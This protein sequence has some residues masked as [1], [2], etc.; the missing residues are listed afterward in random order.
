M[1]RRNSP[2]SNKSRDSVVGIATSFGLGDRGLGSFPGLIKNFNVFISFTPALGSTQP[3]I[4]W[5]LG[6]FS[7]GV[8]LTTPHQLVQ[9]SRKREY[10]H[11]PPPP[12]L[13]HGIVLNY[14]IMEQLY[15]YILP[16]SSGVLCKECTA[17]G[18]LTTGNMD[19]N[20]T[21]HLLCV[22]VCVCV[23]L[24]RFRHCDGP[25]SLSRSTY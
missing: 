16:N 21:S 22:C 18:P 9:R 11:P 7:W 3:S 24:C 19:M 2:D 25:I 13:L 5:V 10:I 20:A 1:W 6:A 4:Q 23:A 15:R 12:M 17:F 14:W 8:K